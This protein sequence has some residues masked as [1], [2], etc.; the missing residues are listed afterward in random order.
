MWYL[1]PKASGTIMA[2]A[3]VRERPPRVSSSSTLSKTAE[4]LPPGATTGS[5]RARSSPKSG[6]ARLAS[7]A[8]MLFT[9]RR[10]VLISPLW[11][12]MRKGWARN[13][14]GEVLVL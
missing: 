14:E 4:S 7:R 1:V 9:L 5:R 13:Q 8:R 3:W 12:A 11:A 2:M 6:E 10:R